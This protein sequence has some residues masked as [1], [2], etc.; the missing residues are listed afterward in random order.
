MTKYQYNI[1]VELKDCILK[2]SSKKVVKSYLNQLECIATCLKD[3]ERIKVID[4]YSMLSEYAKAKTSDKKEFYLRH[5][6]NDIATLAGMVQN[7]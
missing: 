2:C 5:I 4:V 1:I 3:R 6:N 7:V